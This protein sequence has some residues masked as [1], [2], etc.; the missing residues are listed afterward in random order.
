MVAS[1]AWRCELTRAYRATRVGSSMTSVS[2]GEGGKKLLHGTGAARGGWRLAG[3]AA[4]GRRPEPGVDKAPELLFEARD[5][6]D[7]LERA[8]FGSAF[9][10]HGSPAEGSGRRR[11]AALT[12]AFRAAAATNEGRQYG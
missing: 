12:A 6:V 10:L 1:S 4:V 7:A 3:R 9:A 8:L 11:P 2:W 5:E